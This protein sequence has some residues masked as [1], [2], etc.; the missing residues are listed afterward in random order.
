M[1]GPNDT[2]EQENLVVKTY[3]STDEGVAFLVQIDGLAIYHAGDLNWWHWEGEN[4]PKEN[5]YAEDKFKSG[6]DGIKGRDIDLAFVPLDPRQGDFYYLGFDYFMRNT[7]TKIAFPMHMWGDFSI[8]DT[9]INSK[10]AVNYKDKIVKISNDN[11]S[12]NVEL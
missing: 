6:I 3:R 1:I 11:E 10:Y 2:V 12:F 5:K 7:N 8:C 4:S 9:F